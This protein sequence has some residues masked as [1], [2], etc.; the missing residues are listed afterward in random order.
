MKLGD[1]RKQ[2]RRQHERFSIKANDITYNTDRIVGQGS[3]G[4]VFQATRVDTNETVA[5]KKVLQ[6]RRYKNREL[7]IM[8]ELSHRNIVGLLNSFYTSYGNDEVYLNLVLEFVSQTVHNVERHYTKFLSQRVPMILIK[9]CIYQL[10]RALGYIHASG[11]CHR[12]IK[13]HNLLMDPVTGVLKLCDF[14]SAKRLIKGEPNVSYIC[15][16]P[17]R[18]PELLLGATG[19]TTSIDCWSAGC[20]LGE[21]LLGAPLFSADGPLEQLIAIVKLIG[22]PTKE[23]IYAMNHDHVGFKLPDINPIPMEEVFG[24]DTPPEAIDL[25]KKLLRFVPSERL[26]PL[27][28]CCHPFFNELRDPSTRMPDGRPLPVLFDFD[29]RELAYCPRKLCN[30]LVP[31]HARTP[32]QEEFFNSSSSGMSLPPSSFLFFSL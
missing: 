18:A 28:A 16:R 15:S 26:H 10:F 25:L 24:P 27:E 1:G 32:E 20:V 23:E 29:A 8:K 17:Y 14:G 4:V 12:D 2:P 31:P 22:T 30:I 7:Q 9:L 13:P 21:M 5:I 6:D 3:F 11:V 19:Y